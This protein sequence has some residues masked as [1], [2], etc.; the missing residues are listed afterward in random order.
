MPRRKTHTEFIAEIQRLVDDEYIFYG[1]YQSTH[2]KMEV[3]HSKCGH[4]YQ[5]TPHSFLKGSRCP[6][7]RGYVGKGPK[8]MS[9]EQ[10]LK[11]VK[12]LVGDE[13]QVLSK[14]KNYVTKVLMLHTKC[15]KTFQSVPAYF[16]SG[17]GCPNC[18]R[19]SSIANRTK[20]HD[21]FLKEVYKLVGNEYT[22]LETYINSATK[23]KV[24]HNSCDFEYL[25]RPNDF[26]KGHRCPKCASSKGEGEIRDYLT[27]MNIDFKEQYKFERCKNERPLPFDF[28]IFENDNLVMLIEYDGIQHFKASEGWGGIEKFNRTKQNDNIKNNFCQQNKIR[29]LRIKYTDFKRIESVL[30]NYF[31]KERLFTVPKQLELL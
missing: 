10:F 12:D 26:R 4:T 19:K 31:Y 9:H 20:T 30:E 17:N 3:T 14:Y 23:I 15:S 27:S 28:A 16:F 21:S 11:R 29:L 13:Y 25:V 5:V 8:P 24:R 1:E 7:C 22:F 6:K 2:K 18:G